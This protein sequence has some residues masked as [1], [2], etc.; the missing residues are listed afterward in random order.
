[1]ADTA[2]YIGIDLGTG[3]ARCIM[4]DAAGQVLATASATLTK[5]NSASEPGHSEQ[6]PADWI[7][8]LESAMDEVITKVPSQGQVAAIAVDSTSGTVLAVD[9]QGTPLTPALLHNDMR[10]TVEAHSC[11]EALG[12][13][14][15]PTFGLAKMLWLYRH[16]DLPADA[17][18]VH[19]TDF[20][21]EWL[22]GRQV[23]TDFTNAMKT[24]VDLETLSWPQSIESVGLPVE[25]LP[26]IARPGEPLGLLRSELATRWGLTNDVTV[27]AGA[28]DSNAG[29]YASGAAAIGEWCTTIGTTLAI[30]GVADRP[31]SDPAG[32]IYNHRHPDLHWLPGGASNAGGEI[33]RHWFD[34]AE[35]ADL[36]AAAATLGQS[37]QLVY[38]S[39]RSGERLPIADADFQPFHVGSRDDKVGAYLA[40]LEGV[41]FVERWVYDRLAELG[42]PVGDVVFASGGGTRSDVWLQL[43][44]DILQKTVRVAECAESAMGAAILAAAGHRGVSVGEISR[45][46]VRVEREFQPTTDE[47]RVAYFNTK[48]H[49]FKEHAEH[50]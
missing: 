39:V 31:V 12:V 26:E 14:I 43:R 48:Y 20:V 6:R 21:N 7:A 3:G 50:A 41:G 46:M 36:D 33:L 23:A 30:K 44:A 2:L 9:S 34:P 25:M 1:M 16:A 19:A 29:F 24:G 15:S 18:F 10:S 22:C 8:A 4:A 11:S 47:P 28:T 49:Q 45:Q 38:P 13:P 5:E 32:C 17:R 35:F 42:A 37:K 27:V 40:C